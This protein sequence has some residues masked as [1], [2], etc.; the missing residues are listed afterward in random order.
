[1]GQPAGQHA[2]RVPQVLR[3]PGRDRRLH[4]RL[5]GRRA[6]RAS[7]ES[8][9]RLVEAAAARGGG[10]PRAPASAPPAGAA[11]GGLIAAPSARRD[12]SRRYHFGSM[13]LAAKLAT[14]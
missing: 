8:A 13:T 2:E 11:G 4:G 1:G 12:F 6:A 5:D 7:S 14:E 9:P 10:R 3:A